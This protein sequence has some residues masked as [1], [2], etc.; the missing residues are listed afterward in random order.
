MTAKASLP[1]LWRIVGRV[2]DWRGGDGQ[3]GVAVS[4]GFRLV[5]VPQSVASLRFPSP[6]ARTQ[7][8]GIA[9]AIVLPNHAVTLD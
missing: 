2:E 9:K 5:P 6:P 3:R 1:S 8:V 7:R 4:G